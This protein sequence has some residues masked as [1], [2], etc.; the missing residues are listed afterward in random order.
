MIRTAI[1]DGFSLLATKV[2]VECF[3]IEAVLFAVCFP[4]LLI[5]LQKW[6]LPFMSMNIFYHDPSPYPL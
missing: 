2:P 4:A 5:L 1:I 3:I 6:K